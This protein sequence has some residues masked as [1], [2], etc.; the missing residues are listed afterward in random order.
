MDKRIYFV[1]RSPTP[2][3]KTLDDK[4]DYQIYQTR[5]LTNAVEENRSTLK[6]LLLMVSRLLD[7]NVTANYTADISRQHIENIRETNHS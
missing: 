6:R 4:M 7:T 3:P 2:L 5:L 1:D